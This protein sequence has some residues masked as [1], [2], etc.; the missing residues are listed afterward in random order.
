MLRVVFFALF[1]FTASLACAQ[2]VQDSQTL[3]VDFELN[4]FWQPDGRTNFE[5]TYRIDYPDLVFHKYENSIAALLEL[6]CDFYKGDQMVKSD[7]TQAIVA[8]SKW[9]DTRDPSRYHLDK[10][11]YN[12]SSDAFTLRVS[13]FNK[14]RSKDNETHARACIWEGQLITMDGALLSDMDICHSIT[15]DLGNTKPRFVRDNIRYTVNPR[16]TYTLPAEDSL[17]IYYQINPPE[18]GQY[19]Q[20]LTLFYHGAPVRELER[21]SN[22]DKLTGFSWAVNLDDLMEGAY[23]LS[24]TVAN[25]VDSLA[26]DMVDDYISVINPKNPRMQVFED[27]EDDYRLIRYFISAKDDNLWKAMSD[28]AKITYV[29]KYWQNPATAKDGTVVNIALVR[30]RLTKANQLYTTNFVPGWKTDRGR[31]YIRNGEPDE[32][33]TGKTDVN[34][35]YAIKDWEVWQ[36]RTKAIRR[37]L[38][39]DFQENSLFQLIHSEDDDYENGRSDWQDMMGSDFDFDDI[40]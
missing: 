34:T 31:I 21:T 37:Y 13:V 9:E 24:L 16:H 25:P 28:E 33:F 2:W 36:Y 23:Q 38:F 6:H 32:V 27:L 5:L 35:R 4:R 10:I 7:T 17:Y 30:E 3:P 8:V 14:Y 39:V 22:L 1:I 26:T 15:P 20:H 29:Q 11:M 18:T 12:L 19:N 40:K